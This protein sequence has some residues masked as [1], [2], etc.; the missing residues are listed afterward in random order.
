MQEKE[1]YKK[2]LSGNMAS[3]SSGSKDYR[4]EI[5]KAECKHKKELRVLQRKH[6]RQLEVE[7][8]NQSGLSDSSDGSDSDDAS[9]ASMNSD[10]TNVSY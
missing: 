4:K 9:D 3:R 1:E 8:L 6:K 2:K 5:K 10:D 7:K